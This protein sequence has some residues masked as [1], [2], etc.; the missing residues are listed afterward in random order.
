MELLPPS[1]DDPDMLGLLGEILSV[2]AP[3]SSR[4]ALRLRMMSP[5][6][7]W[8]ALVA[9]ASQQGVIIP[10][11]HT[12]RRDGLLLPVRP[13]A[14]PA[15]RDSH[16]TTR[17]EQAYC[18]HL[19]RRADLTE[20]TRTII[21]A[22]NAAGIA[23]LLLKGCRHLVAP[24]TPLCEARTMRDL[25]LCV[26]PDRLDEAVRIL[27][28]LGYLPIEY[29]TPFDHH[30]P[31]MARPGRHG[32][33]EIHADALALGG[34][35]VL[36]TSEV[37][38]LCERVSTPDGTFHVLPAHWHLLHGLL[39]HQVA[40]RGHQRRILA[41]KGL[42]EFA[43]LGAAMS[44]EQWQ[45]IAD[46]MTERGQA[47]ALGS[48][49]YQAHALFGLMPPAGGLV[50]QAARDHAAATVARAGQPYG[51]RRVG[52]IVDQIRH[53]FS[54]EMLAHRYRI[55]PGD[56]SAGTALRQAVSLCGKYGFGIV[57]RV[58]GR[59]DRAS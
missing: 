1:I 46:H 57:A 28:S 18:E 47:V 7:S 56:V 31:A 11:V 5:D 19:A 29:G 12:L 34:R 55:E 45:E 37:W 41:L 4:L 8:R 20:Q 26:P 33:V 13:S 50:D 40:E 21:A 42:L 17:L 24:M 59:R 2:G 30:A 49:L 32:A 38:R 3:A 53:A 9:L 35:K 58:A 23:P 43:S 10:M 54:R 39:H 48:W 51:R 36:A 27:D 6:F 25:D 14:P 44:P 52:F 15:E 22:L 16:V